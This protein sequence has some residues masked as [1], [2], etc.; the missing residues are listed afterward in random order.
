[1]SFP[2]RVLIVDDEPLV[3]EIFEQ[4]LNTY[5]FDVY[6]ASAAFEALN[7]LERI[8]FDV[9]VCDVM[10]EGL[11]GFEILERA[12]A[13]N[14]RVEFVLI[15]GAPS[16]E[17]LSNALKKSTHY[18]TKPIDIHRLVQTVS[19]CIKAQSHSQHNH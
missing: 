8:F 4:T 7:M 11:N 13:S 5:G 16:K 2:G 15:T 10:L 1:M 12:K 17:G 14:P 9:V 19:S 3:L 18:L 6:T